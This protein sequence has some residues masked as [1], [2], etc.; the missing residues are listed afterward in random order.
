MATVYAP[1][2]GFTPPT[3]NLDDFRSG[4]FE[5]AEQDYLDRLAAR[6]QAN[7]TSPLLGKVVRWQRA[8]GYAEYMVWTTSPLALLHLPLGDAWQV[9]DA[10]IRGLRVSDVRA[11]VERDSALNALFGR[12]A[13]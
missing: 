2:E 13:D 12:K 5:A 4:A 11:M 10:L 8:D 9:E 7:G 6:C 1:P 3:F